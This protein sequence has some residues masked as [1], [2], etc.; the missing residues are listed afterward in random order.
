MNSRKRNK[1]YILSR[2]ISCIL[3]DLLLAGLG[4]NFKKLASKSVAPMQVFRNAR[5]G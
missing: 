5:P 2:R 1:N 4:D 3:E